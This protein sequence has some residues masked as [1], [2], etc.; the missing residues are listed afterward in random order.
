MQLYGSKTEQLSRTDAEAILKRLPERIRSALIAPSE[1][2]RFP[3]KAV[4]EMAI[5]S[6]L[7]LE[8]L[9]FAD[10]KPGRGQ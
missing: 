3:I 1:E 5:A 7:D 2:I 9:G 10:C 8:A 4:L 6:F